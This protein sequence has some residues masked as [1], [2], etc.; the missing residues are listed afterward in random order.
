MFPPRFVSFE[1]GPHWIYRASFFSTE[2][3]GY[4]IV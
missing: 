3:D 4:A 1:L 2:V